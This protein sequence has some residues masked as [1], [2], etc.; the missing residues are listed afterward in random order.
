MRAI[1]IGHTALMQCRATGNPIPKIS[2]LKDN[3]RLDMS[4][5]RYSLIDGKRN[6]MQPI[7]QLTLTFSAQAGSLQIIDSVREDQGKFECVAENP[8]GTE[9]SKPMNLYIKERRVPPTFSRLPEPLN[10]VRLGSNLSLECVAVGSPMPLVKWKTGADDIT[11]ED[12]IPI[13]KNVLELANIQNS[14]NYTCVAAS[15]LG[16]IEATAVVKVQCK[17][18]RIFISRLLPVNS[19]SIIL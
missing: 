13:G 4:N 16:K 2:W 12:Q 15:S 14:A 11:P 5:K 19:H 3:K 9:H 17:D 1:E 6:R 18:N 7:N 10:E 8:V